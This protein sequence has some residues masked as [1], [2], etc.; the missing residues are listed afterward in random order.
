MYNISH[1]LFVAGGVTGVFD[2]Q[3][4]V[5]LLR[6]EKARDIC[7]IVVPPELKYVSYL[8]IVTGHSTRHLRAMA[9]YVKWVVS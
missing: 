1:V 4:V 2:V 7:V 3:E 5:D 6:D 9:A 8:V